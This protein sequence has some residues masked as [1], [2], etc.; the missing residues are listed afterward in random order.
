MLFH[1]AP[2]TSPPTIT[3]INVSTTIHADMMMT[4]PIRTLY[5][6]FLPLPYSEALAG[7]VSI[8][9]PAQAKRMAERKTAIKMDALRIF[10][11]RS[12]RLHIVQSVPLQVTITP[13]MPAPSATAG[14][15][16]R[17]IKIPTRTPCRRV[18]RSMLE[19]YHAKTAVRPFVRCVRRAGF[20]QALAL[21]PSRQSSA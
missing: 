13:G 18:R 12:A 6:R 1:G 10:C 20:G 5:R 17:T 15:S 11:A 19:F 7:L 21:S 9:S 14:A 16:A 2:P 3:R 8:R 4:N